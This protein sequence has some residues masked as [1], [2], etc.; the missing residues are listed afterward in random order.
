MVTA[1]RRELREELGIEIENIEPFIFKDGEY[2]KTFPG[3]EK[4]PVYMIFLLFNCRVVGEQIRLNQEFDAYRW[5]APDTLI[6]LNLN[7]ETLDTLKQIGL[8]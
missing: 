1:L 7:V 5:V 2:L 6:D 4:Q 8:L 3:G